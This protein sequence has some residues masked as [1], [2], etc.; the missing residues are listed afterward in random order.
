MFFHL[1][2][3]AARTLVFKA[4]S[5]EELAK[6]ADI[7]KPSAENLNIVYDAELGKNNFVIESENISIPVEGKEELKTIFELT[8]RFQDIPAEIGDVFE[9]LKTLK[10]NFVDDLKSGAFSFAIFFTKDAD[11]V[12][13]LQGLETT[14]GFQYFLS[15]DEALAEKLGASFPSVLAYNSVDKC[16]LN[17]P[18]YSTFN[19]LHAAMTIKAFSKITPDNFRTLQFL[20][21]NIFYVIDKL[22]NYNKVKESF[23]TMMKGF[24]S[25]AKFVYFIPDEIPA[26]IDLIN[27]NESQYPL[28]I[29]LSKEGKSIVRGLT[30]DN[31]VASVNSLID[32]TA[33][34][35]RFVSKIP[36][37]NDTRAVKVLNSDVVESVIGNQSVDRLIAFTSPKCSHCH[38]LKPVFDKFAEALQSRNVD[39]FIGGYNVIENEEFAHAKITGVP[40]MY[41]IKKGSKEL[42]KLP[43]DARSLQALLEFVAKEGVSASVDLKDYADIISVPQEPVSEIPPMVDED[44]TTSD[45]S[46]DVDSGFDEEELLEVEDSDKAVEEDYTPSPENQTTEK[47][48]L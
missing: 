15:S 10:S 19:A 32:K 27:T 3:V 9:S 29:N 41:Y 44:D 18:Y 4:P 21:Q 22:E 23:E 28:L 33:E 40:T 25:D 14:S 30:V 48:V 35:L 6:V 17:L 42:I 37:D 38:Q 8:E 39:I 20:E 1:I 26:L 24:S 13:R 36:A 31:F 45:S 11:D 5:S 47:T 43:N 2:S 7:Y 16:V 46:L 12:K 34:T